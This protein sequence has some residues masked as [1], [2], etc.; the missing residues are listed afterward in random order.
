[1]QYQNSFPSILES[2]TETMSYE[3]N[4]TGNLFKITPHRPQRRSLTESCDTLKDI[5][6]LGAEKGIEEQGKGMCGNLERMTKEKLDTATCINDLKQLSKE[7]IT[8]NY[9]S[10][11]DNNTCS[12]KKL[13]LM[14]PFEFV[15]TQAK[16]YRN[17]KTIQAVKKMS[18]N[19]PVDLRT[20]G[21]ERNMETAV[22]RM[23]T[24][25]NRIDAMAE[26][27]NITDSD[28]KV[29]F[30][31]LNPGF[32]TLYDSVKVHCKKHSEP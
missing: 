12:V 22:T 10:I 1:M 28:K 4:M 13:H 17:S 31:L 2:G 11:I 29:F 18:D 27:R 7:Y 30:G 14:N 8:Q 32:E 21:Y 19:V 25:F 9:N 23:C 16:K 26:E 6:V 15:N 5:V 3:R 20:S 24:Q